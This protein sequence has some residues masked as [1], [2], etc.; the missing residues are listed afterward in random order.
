[1]TDKI[2]NRLTGRDRVNYIASLAAALPFHVLLIYSIQVNGII[3]AKTLL[4]MILNAVILF[5]M[6]KFMK[7]IYNETDN[8]IILK[9]LFLY[10]IL[11][12]LICFFLFVQGNAF[13]IGNY[14]TLQEY[15][16]YFMV[17]EED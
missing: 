8:K 1:M 4:Y 14:D 3:G 7:F 5:T 10:E 16:D 2:I 6:F 17:I 9:R 12:V 11:P 15:L 13:K